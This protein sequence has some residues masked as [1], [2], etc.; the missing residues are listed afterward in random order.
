MTS[1][2]GEFLAGLSKDMDAFLAKELSAMSIQEREKSYYD[3]HGVAD[4]VAETPELIEES[5]TK[6]DEELG[7]ISP[8]NKEAYLLAEAEDKD[9]TSYRRFRLQFLRR[10]AFDVQATAERI[11]L[12]FE[13][14][15][16]FFGPK[17]LAKEIKLRDLD[18]YDRRWLESGVGQ[19][20]PQRD[21]AGRG[22]FIWILALR[23][24]NGGNPEQVAKS[25]VSSN[26]V[27]ISDFHTK[28]PCLISYIISG[29]Y[30]LLPLDGCE[31]RRGSAEKRNGGSYYC[32]RQQTAVQS[33]SLKKCD[34]YG[35]FT[36]K[37]LA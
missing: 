6:L 11:I 16:K 26:V 12:F 1:S 20:L 34:R 19:L 4:A 35:T 9:Y 24:T 37:S 17:L 3:V 18:E 5:L 36:S 25:K 27:C 14:K 15:L 31:R 13:T 28:L 8:K 23:P 32:N 29:T 10:E 2:N 7:K 22:V 33:R 30:L 21:R